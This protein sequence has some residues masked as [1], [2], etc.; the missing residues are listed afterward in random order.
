MKPSFESIIADFEKETAVD[1]IGLWQLIGAVKRNLEGE[2]L[3]R[4]TLDLSTQMLS[5]GF[6]VGDMSSSGTTLEPWPDQRPAHVAAR[7]EAEW[8]ALGREPNIGDIAWF[9]HIANLSPVKH[10]SGKL[11]RSSD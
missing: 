6:L 8:N 1:L 7:I 11:G 5:R 2:H 4:L 3:Q 10:G 9:D